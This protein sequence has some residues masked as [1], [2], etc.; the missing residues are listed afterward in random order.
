[1]IHSGAIVGAMVTLLD[2][3][4]SEGAGMM[5]VPLLTTSDHGRTEVFQLR[6]ALASPEP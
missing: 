2:Q 1:M 4:G 3:F 5:Q 6:A